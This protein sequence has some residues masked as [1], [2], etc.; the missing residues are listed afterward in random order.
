MLGNTQVLFV[1][2]AAWALHGERPGR[3]VFLG[4]PLA[5]AGMT[6]VSGLGRADAYGADPVLGTLLGLATGVTYSVFL[7]AFR[8]STGEG[9][10]PFAPFLV[11]TIGVV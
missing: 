8:R 6:F 10:S 9:E 11:A 2:F 4:V 1:G 3:T 5:F 7:L